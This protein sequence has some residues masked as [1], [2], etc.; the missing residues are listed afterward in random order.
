METKQTP[1]NHCSLK[2]DSS[3]TGVF[4]GYA[5]V[6]DSVDN[7][8]DTIVR[9]AF[10][11]S[12]VAGHRIKMFINHNHK[13]IP[14]GTWTEFEEDDH[15][16]YGKGSINFDHANG[17]SLYSALKRSDIDGLSIGFS[18]NDDDFKI[19]SSGG[20]IIK[21]LS[22]KEVS[23]VTFPCEEKATI[24]NVKFDEAQ[25]IRDLEQMIRDEF[26]CSKAVACN[27]LSHAKRILAGDLAQ[28]EK[29]I[30]ELELQISKQ[31]VDRLITLLKG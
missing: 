28:N 25:T 23:V 1:S 24:T 31:N 29:R 19:K 21:N 16:L 20:R 22:L 14:V 10:K 13:E 26:H 18:M 8:G 4:E 30:R 11:S 17:K 6:F 9:G 5:S 7:V 3:E 27:F 2:F 12:L 15:G